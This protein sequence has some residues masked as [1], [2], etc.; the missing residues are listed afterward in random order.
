[1][2]SVNGAV[3]WMNWFRVDPE[4]YGFWL[5]RSEKSIVA[6]DVREKFRE[7]PLPD[8]YLRDDFGPLDALY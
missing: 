2:V 7:M 6:F 1:M 8:G 4:E 3:H 5:E